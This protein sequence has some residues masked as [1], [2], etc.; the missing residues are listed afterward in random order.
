MASKTFIGLGKIGLILSGPFYFAQRGPK[1][2]EAGC[3]I[4]TGLPAI[5]R[6]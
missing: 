2:L 4:N 3:A 5:S 1:F 6:K